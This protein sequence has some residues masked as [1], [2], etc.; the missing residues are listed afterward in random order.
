MHSVFRII[1]E[2]PGQK[3]VLG[4]IMRDFNAT[5]EG[6]FTEM[7]KYDAIS[8]TITNKGSWEDHCDEIKK[9]IVQNSGLL[10]C[11]KNETMCYHIDVCIKDFEDIGESTITSYVCEVDFLS[12]LVAN[13]VSLEFSYYN[14]RD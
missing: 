6:L 13:D 9:F 7:R 1:S 12:L 10:N 8:A 14:T 2:K 5:R 3:H 11:Y 4:Q